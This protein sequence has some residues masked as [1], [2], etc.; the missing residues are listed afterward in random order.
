MTG[1]ECEGGM[2][3]PFACVRGRERAKRC[4]RGMHCQLLNCGH[5]PS[6]LRF[7]KGEIP[8]S[9]RNDRRWLG[10]TGGCSESQGASAITGCEC[11]GGESARVRE[12]IYADL[13]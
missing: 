11:E 6:P 13:C 5:P 2:Y 4:E 9:A 1:C 10:M 3:A 7:T 8:R 12:R